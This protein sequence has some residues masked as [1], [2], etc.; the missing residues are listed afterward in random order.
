MIILTINAGSSSL[1]FKLIKTGKSEKVLASGHIDGIGLKSCKFTFTSDHK[2]IGVKT[3]VS[4]HSEAIKTALNTLIK[5]KAIQ[6]FSEIDAI[7]H[8]VVHGGE[9]YVK[10]VKIDAKIIKDLERLSP[11]APLHNPPN[12]KGIKA[13]KKILPRTRQVAVFDTAFHQTM[14]EK[15]FLY[16]IPYKYYEKSGIR[17]Y[18][19]H[20]TS[21]Q[22][23]VNE[24]I[25]LLKKKNARIITCHIGNGTSITASINGKSVDTSM[26]FTPLEG[27]MMGTR[28][29]SIDPAIIFYLCDHEKEKLKD[30]EYMLNYESGLKGF[31]GISPD[32]RK[33]Y[34]E[35]LNKNKDA[36]RTIEVLSY[37]IV[38]YCG[39]YIAAMNGLDAITFTA[40][41]GEKAFYVREQVL[42]H[43]EF[44]GLKMDKKKNENCETVISAAN[45]KIKAFVIPT[46]EEAEIARQTEKTL[47]K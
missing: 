47:K 44:L 4:D 2:D 23:V 26:G 3:P 39:A 12:I 7:G 14:P 43:L 9:K 34:G 22:Y 20:G 16:G 32:M 42:K 28:S 15:A 6:K 36:L 33:I 40:G 19:F 37:Q 35:S 24:T 1:K 11:L 29:G 21:H 30:I 27:V 38:R 25:K 45:S 10:S 18:G 5:S 17:R 31:S 41:L 13:C 46:N 8:R